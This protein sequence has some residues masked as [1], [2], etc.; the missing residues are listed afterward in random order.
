MNDASLVAFVKEKLPSITELHNGQGDV[1]RRLLTGTSSLAIIP[2]GGGKSLLWLLFISIAGTKGSG[3]KPLCIVLVPYKALITNHIE[4]TKPWFQETEIV[5]SED[6]EEKIIANI[7]R[8]SIV[9]MTP[10]KY[11]RNTRFKNMVT[12]Q[13]GRTQLVVIDK[14]HLVQEQSKFRPD[15]I[16]CVRSM[17][18]NFHSTPRLALTATSEVA[19]VATLLEVACMPQNT[20]I[21]RVSC[22]RSNFHIEIVPMLASKRK[23]GNQI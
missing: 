13:C 9:Y 23:Q 21:T 20:C 19:H 8:A 3:V 11:V 15:M 4:A 1:M 6:S 12:N 17:A 22:N 7:D 2:T 18:R 5:T 10:E 16:E 14:V